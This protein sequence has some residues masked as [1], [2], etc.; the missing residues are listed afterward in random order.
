VEMQRNHVPIEKGLHEV[1]EFASWFGP[2]TFK[3]P[4]IIIGTW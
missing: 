3:P 4:T 1:D 2:N